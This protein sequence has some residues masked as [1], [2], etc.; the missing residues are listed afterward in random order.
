MICRGL[1]L[2]KRAGT[3][4]GVVW[5]REGMGYRNIVWGDIWR[6]GREVLDVVAMMGR[7]LS[8]T[9]VS[10]YSYLR[11]VQTQRLGEEKIQLRKNPQ[12]LRS[13]FGTRKAFHHF[14]RTYSRRDLSPLDVQFLFIFFM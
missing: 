11:R 7:L 4:W 13:M 3:L 12:L 2:D 9:T 10:L 6:S 5:G 8:S 14:S 1:G